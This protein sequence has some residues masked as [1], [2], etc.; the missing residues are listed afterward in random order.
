MPEY[1]VS[2]ME[3]LELK[4]LS[5]INISK[6]DGYLEWF[7]ANRFL[8]PNGVEVVSVDVM[9]FILA[10]IKRERDASI[11]E[12]LK[13]KRFKA[14]NTKLKNRNEVLVKELNSLKKELKEL[15]MM[16]GRYISPFT[17][18]KELYRDN[19]F[20]YMILKKREEFKIK[21]SQ[22]QFDYWIGVFISLKIIQRIDKGNVQ[23]LLG[24]IDANQTLYKNNSVWNITDKGDKLEEIGYVN[25]NETS[26]G[27]SLTA[28]EK[29]EITK[30]L[31]K[32]WGE[33]DVKK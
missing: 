16:Y 27:E 19:S 21:I 10:E 2:A 17:I 25:S 6:K 20:S 31:E 23:S 13:N 12:A 5:S 3:I 1:T 26:G 30:D 8:F 24:F 29:E 15:N 18:L 22:K 28:D 11:S 4:S 14:Q 32:E 9:L 7:D 33:R